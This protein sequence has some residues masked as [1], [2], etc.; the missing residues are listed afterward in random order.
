MLAVLGLVRPAALRA[1]SVLAAAEAYAQRVLLDAGEVEG[2]RL[3]GS[4]PLSA[5]GS[6]ALAIRYAYFV[7][8][9]PAVNRA[10]DF[11]VY[12]Y[13]YAAAEPARRQIANIRNNGAEI[14]GDGTRI[15]YRWA[16]S[17]SGADEAESFRVT[18]RFPDGRAVTGSGV[19]WR[20]DTVTFIL[21]GSS[22][23]GTDIESE[24]LRLASLQNG[25]A[26]QVGPFRPPQPGQPSTPV[27]PGLAAPEP[28]MLLLV[29]ALVN[30]EIVQ[31]G[32]VVRAY[33]GG[34][35]CGEGET[36]FGWTFLAVESGAAQ[37]GCGVPGAT[38]TFTIAGVPANETVVWVSGSFARGVMITSSA[39]RPAG[40]VL[41]RPVAS[42]Q[43]RPAAG[44]AGCSAQDE[45]LWNGDLETWL[46]VFAERGEEPSGEAL[47]RAWARFRADR[48]EVL[49]GMV[50]A[51]L[52]GRPY[53]FISAV[54]Y[55]PTEEFPDVYVEIANLGGERPVGN[56][57]VET[58]DGGEY[59]FPPDAVLPT[60]PCRIYLSEEAAARGRGTCPGAVL[61]GSALTRPGAVYLI[62]EQ[63]QI[64]DAVGF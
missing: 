44:E 20:R 59:I 45:R 30:G 23:P 55:R 35:E 47:L 51:V 61:S 37:P 41:V 25:K 10:V 40:G 2:Y 64:V 26:T 16:G 22:P 33:V 4:S 1:Q 9:P 12:V 53:T 8:D 28:A 27:G 39:D 18:V 49:G 58:T 32:T 60:G 56:W 17:V 38:V 62:D 5:V 29:V 52:D 46:G 21:L 34:Q 42:V 7:A 3:V 11:Y 19:G 43:C 36:I 13:V 48:G 14:T 24:V 31:D 15:G 57:R 54:R 6:Q 63:G 50:L